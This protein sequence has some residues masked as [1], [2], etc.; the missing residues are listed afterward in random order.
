LAFADN[1]SSGLEPPFSWTYT[2]K[3][4]MADGSK[5]EYQVEDHAWRL[6]KAMGGDMENLPPQ[7]VTALEISAE[8]HMKMLAAVQRHVDAACSKTVNVP[9]DYPFKNFKG[10]YM[11]AWK[12]GLKGIA[13]YRPNDITGSVLSVEP[14]ELE[15]APQP[16]EPAPQPTPPVS[17]GFRRW[18]SRPAFPQGVSSR[19]YATK[20][21][22]GQYLAVHVAFDDDAKPFEVW[23]SGEGCDPTLGA[24]A[25]VLSLLMQATDERPAKKMLSKLSEF[26]V[27]DGEF[28]EWSLL[29]PGKKRSYPS[30]VAYLADGVS[31]AYSLAASSANLPDGLVAHFTDPAM[32]RVH[33][34][35]KKCPHC[36]AFAVVKR[37]G[38]DFCE[39]CG[40]I[41]ACG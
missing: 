18:A 34:S 36:G 30:Q 12:A 40:A 33:T 7:F 27:R 8:D 3:K 15:V 14:A 26:H 32:P 22:D 21:R 24:L 38:C 19:T 28:F 6:Y 13:T 37:D 35:G 25:M 39:A 23:V 5:M 11:Q 4:R 20:L 41:G 17:E 10:L 31:H 29:S 1:A 2:R 9:A 16:P